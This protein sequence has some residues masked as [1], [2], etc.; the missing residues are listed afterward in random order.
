MKSIG[1][2]EKCTPPATGIYSL[3]VAV[4][5]P[6]DISNTHEVFSKYS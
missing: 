3:R 6:G 5:T 2:V 1:R 4:T